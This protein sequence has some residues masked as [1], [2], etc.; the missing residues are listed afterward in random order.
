MWPGITEPYHR[1]L[2][3]PPGPRLTSNSGGTRAARRPKTSADPPV[4][5]P[6]PGGGKRCTDSAI[7]RPATHIGP[8]A[9]LARPN[10]PRA[11]RG[12]QPAGF[13]LANN[14]SYPGPATARP[15]RT[16]ALH[17]PSRGSVTP[18]GQGAGNNTGRDIRRVEQDGS[19]TEDPHAGYYNAGL[20]ADELATSYGLPIRWGSKVPA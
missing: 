10:G 16:L 7:P 14:L 13:P 6:G 18:T 4:S 19:L 1:N 11:S 8:R 12:L 3:E 20:K 5:K 17:G 15:R 2:N 9:D